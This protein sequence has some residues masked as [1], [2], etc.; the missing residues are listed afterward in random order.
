[1][2][3]TRLENYLRQRASGLQREI[4]S[5]KALEM[6]EREN[7]H[8]NSRMNVRELDRFGER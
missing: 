6:D 5:T 4:K 2:R 3:A 8:G 1:M 7:K